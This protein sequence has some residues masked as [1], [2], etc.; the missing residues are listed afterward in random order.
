MRGKNGWSFW[1]RGVG[2]R[3]FSAS[4]S[5]GELE[6]GLRS[7]WMDGMARKKASAKGRQ[8]G[9]SR[10]KMSTMVRTRMCS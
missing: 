4:V 10:R 2:G 8:S 9:I 6:C 5:V 3:R 7:M 1:I